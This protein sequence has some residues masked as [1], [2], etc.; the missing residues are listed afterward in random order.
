[1]ELFRSGLRP[2]VR[3]LIGNEPGRCT[4]RIEV[5]QIEA[6]GSTHQL[7][8][9]Q[10]NLPSEGGR[11]SS[12]LVYRY[13]ILVTQVPLFPWRRAIPPTIYCPVCTA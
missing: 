1:M 6:Y 8:T 9:R 13:T 5:E 4:H 12:L 2:Q 3:I 11:P 10:H 7:A